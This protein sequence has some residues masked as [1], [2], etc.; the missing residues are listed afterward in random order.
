MQRLNLFLG[1]DEQQGLDKYS[2]NQNFGNHSKR[3]ASGTDGHHDGI[4]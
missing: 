4:C 3:S 1:L 2:S